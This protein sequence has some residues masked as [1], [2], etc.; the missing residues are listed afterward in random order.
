MR[1]ST[2]V[3]GLRRDPEQLKEVMVAKGELLRVTHDGETYYQ[4]TDAYPDWTEAG[5][6]IL[7][8]PDVRPKIS[9]SHQDCQ[10]TSSG[11]SLL[12]RL[13]IGTASGLAVATFAVV[14]LSSPGEVGM[15]GGSSSARNHT[16]GTAVSRL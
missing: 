13:G 10:E 11:R 7:T 1:M 16:T 12:R 2:A 4:A 5:Q 8:L 3:G 9:R 6:Q 15:A 14:A